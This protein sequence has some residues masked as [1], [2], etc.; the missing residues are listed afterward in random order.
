MISLEIPKRQSIQTLRGTCS[1]N[2]SLQ[3]LIMN[4]KN[5]SAINI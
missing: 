2:L 5:S 1:N 4:K 3:L